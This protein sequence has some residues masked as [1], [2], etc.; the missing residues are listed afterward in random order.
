VRRAIRLKHFS[1][2]TEQAYVG[3]IRRFIRFHALRHPSQLHAPELAAFLSDLAVRG[4]VSAST[5][6][7]ALAALLFLY[8]D[9]LRLDPGR[10]PELTRARRPSTTPIVLSPAEVDLV[11]RRISGVP[12]LVAELLYGSGL[13]L[14]EALRLRVKDV[15]FARGRLVI[16]EPKGGKDRMTVLPQVLGDGLRRQIEHAR[17]VHRADVEAGYGSISLPG[18]LARKFPLATRA[19]QWQWV[20]PATRRHRAREGGERRHHLHP[21]LIQRAFAEAVRASGISKRA[22]CH[23]LRHSFATHLLTAGYDIRVVQDLLGHRDVRTTMIYTHV[24]DRGPLGVRS[25]MDVLLRNGPG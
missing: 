8:R 12:R 19:W 9:V 5:Q 13:R 2:R 20:F 4:R 24:L 23:S 11:I 3:W 6:N 21:T 1:R 14:L 7:Q 22:T 18:A 25:P 10:L 15:D 16:H 17:A